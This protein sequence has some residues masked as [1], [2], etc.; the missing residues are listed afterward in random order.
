MSPSLAVE[1]LKWSSLRAQVSAF[2]GLVLFGIA[3]VW[4]YSFAI[5]LQWGFDD[6]L[7][8]SGLSAVSDHVGFLNFISGG[9]AGPTGRPVS[10]LA[11]IPDYQHWPNNPMGFVYGSLIWHGL[12]VALVFLVVFRLIPLSKTLKDV[13]P[14]SG[15][16]LVACIW[17]GLAVHASGILMPVQRMTHISAFFSLVCIALYLFWRGLPIDKAFHFRGVLLLFFS[18]TS[19]ILSVYAKEN[20]VVTV[21]YIALIELLLLSSSPRPVAKTWWKVLVYIALLAVPAAM[22]IMFQGSWMALFDD[23]PVYRRDFDHEQRLATQA[24]ILWEYVRTIALPRVSSMGPYH[25][26]HA[27]Y[28]WGSI[29]TWGA[30]LA[31]L[32]VIAISAVLAKKYRTGK[33]LL[34]SVLFFLAGHQIESS[35]ILLELYFE[36]RNY[37]PALG[38]ALLCVVVL[39]KLKKMLGSPIVPA[40]VLVAIMT[41]NLFSVQ[42]VASIW[43]NP[44]AAAELW[45]REH[46]GSSRAVQ[47]LA[48]EYQK[49][50]FLD[51]GVRV[52]DEFVEEGSEGRL[53]VAIQAVNLACYIESEET[54]EKR[55][56]GLAVHIAN[57]SNV[58]GISTSLGAFGNTVRRGQCVG[59]STPVYQRFL[60]EL[61]E[62]KRV[63]NS[64]PILHHVYFELALTYEYTDQNDE[65]IH[66]MQESYRAYPSLTIAQ[67]IAA[68]LFQLRELDK[69]IA[70]LDEAIGYAPEGFQGS[71]WLRTLGSMRNALIDIKAATGG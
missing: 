34:F 60:F 21:T 40:V 7:N 8:L 55:F 33:V 44:L 42:Q 19:F 36:H 24:V 69:A 16:L 48:R 64:K 39:F 17:G 1:R 51:A 13:S 6:A 45:Y 37:M 68:E 53:D 18:G 22:L 47:M 67:K 71:I 61:L 30:V 25:D 62:S 66:Y 59:I 5:G 49:H 20:G 11:F 57:L 4:L 29:L 46:P 56:E 12:N 70:W 23:A 15:A 38:G 54:L 31:W 27:I 58:S 50:G 26:G 63:A 35:I 14:L 41:L 43:G 10:L 2:A 28:G 32:V 9:V 52:L 3:L 65:Y